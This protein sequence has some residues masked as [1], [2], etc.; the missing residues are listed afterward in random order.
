MDKI[1]N[2][3]LKN[4]NFFGKR[5]GNMFEIYKMKTLALKQPSTRLVEMQQRWA[6]TTTNKYGFKVKINA[7]LNEEV[8]EIDKQNINITN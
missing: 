3:R 5:R 4:E 6:Y 7:R 8:G 1:V 2:K